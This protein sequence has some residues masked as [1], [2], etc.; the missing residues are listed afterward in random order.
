VMN[1][2]LQGVVSGVLYPQSRYLSFAE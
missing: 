2:K 1:P